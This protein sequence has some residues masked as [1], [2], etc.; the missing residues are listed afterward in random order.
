M[1]AFIFV[2]RIYTQCLHAVTLINE[3]DFLSYIL[4]PDYRRTKIHLSISLLLYP[5]STQQHKADSSL[6]NLPESNAAKTT[7]VGT[8][9]GSTDLIGSG[10]TTEAST[11]FN[12]DNTNAQPKAP[13]DKHGDTW[14]G[15]ISHENK[16]C[17]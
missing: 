9:G 4:S 15:G 11:S 8:A 14:G 3:K 7:V 12:T 17:K 13:L 6:N 1:C 16:Q 2:L 10:K 5:M